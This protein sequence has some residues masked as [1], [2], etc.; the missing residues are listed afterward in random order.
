MPDFPMF[1]T[2]LALVE[3]LS[4]PRRG[5]NTRMA[6]ALLLLLV[7]SS[8]AP[9]QETPVRPAPGFERPADNPRQSRSVVMARRGMVATSQPLA[10]QAG[11]R[12]LQQGGTAADAAIAANAVIGVTE[13]MSC[14][15]GG[16][17]FVLY[18][19]AKT[20]TLH[21]LNASGRS[22]LNLSREKFASLGVDEIPVYGPL[23]WSVPGC[24]DGWEELRVKF[25]TR[26]LAELLAPAI[27]YAEEGFPV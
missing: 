17:L 20:R 3:T 16:D 4:Q 12:V 24:V 6:L 8:P 7:G 21:G 5:W 14:G 22:P 25:G 13:P 18:W 1:R 27:E 26:P 9:S 10:V 19:D 15:I 11:L 2:G 23:S